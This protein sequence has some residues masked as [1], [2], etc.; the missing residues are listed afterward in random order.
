MALLFVFPGVRMHQELLEGKTPGADGDVTESG[1]SNS[2]I[3]QKY[4]ETH[5]I[6]YLPERS[7]DRPVLLLY[8]GHKSH[9][10][11]PLIDWAKKENIILFILPAHISHILQPMDVACFG[12][13]EKIYNAM[14][15]KFMREHCGQSISRYNVCSVA[16]P[17]YAKALS[18]ENL[19]SAFRRCR[20]Y[21]FNPNAVDQTNFRPS[22][23][24]QHSE[25]PPA[26]QTHL[27]IISQSNPKS[28][29]LLD[30][31][32]P[33]LGQVN[34]DPASNFFSLKEKKMNEKKTQ[35]KKK[36]ILAR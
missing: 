25:Q 13:F 22:A 15:H 11:L 3:F 19:Q 32:T 5:L 33:P 16:F 12:P 23:V 17:A 35:T 8:D 4:L 6:K 18:P 29:G 26:T 27:S 28:P 20:I 21:L 31:Q 30:S 34:D 2:Q 24:L 36:S 7:I 10:N 14:S 9:V 1:W